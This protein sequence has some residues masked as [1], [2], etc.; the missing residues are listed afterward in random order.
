MGHRG[1]GWPGSGNGGRADESPVRSGGG[2]H[3]GVGRAT[4]RRPYEVLHRIE[5]WRHVGGGA[6]EYG[7]LI[8]K[9]QELVWAELVD[10]L[11]QR[12]SALPSAVLAEDV[13]MLRILALV[14]EGETSDGK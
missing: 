13:E 12:Y 4:D 3:G 6:D 14:A 8:E 5:R 10:T 7:E 11:A 9:P 2:N 1:R